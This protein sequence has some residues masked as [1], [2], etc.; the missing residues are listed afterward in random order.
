M[1]GV[2]CPRR[3]SNSRVFAPWTAASVALVARVSWKWVPLRPRE[4]SAGRQT[5]AP[6]L[7]DWS[8]PPLGP[9]KN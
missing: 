3:R 8:G 9:V 6:K 4:M 1:L 2:E 7:A 5:L